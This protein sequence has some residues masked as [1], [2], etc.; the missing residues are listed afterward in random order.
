MYLGLWMVWN[1]LV[2]QEVDNC[3]QVSGSIIFYRVINKGAIMEDISVDVR[4][5]LSARSNPGGNTNLYTVTNERATAVTL[6]DRQT[7][8]GSGP[9]VLILPHPDKVHICPEKGLDL[10]R[11]IGFWN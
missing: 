9:F 1:L 4:I 5:T 11:E 6:K 7:M 8:L 10:A 2:N 3:N